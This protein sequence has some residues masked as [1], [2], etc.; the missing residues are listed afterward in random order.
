MNK[1]YLLRNVIFMLAHNNLIIIER[2]CFKLTHYVLMLINF[3]A[4]F[5]ITFIFKFS[6]KN[7]YKYN[8]KTNW[9]VDYFNK[10]NPIAYGHQILIF[11]FLADLINIIGKNYSLNKYKHRTWK[12]SWLISLMFNQYFEIDFSIF[13]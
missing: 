7:Y 10:I 13:D 9:V 11:V 3:N 12:W 1:D 6:L 2:N 8:Q 4:G 5:W